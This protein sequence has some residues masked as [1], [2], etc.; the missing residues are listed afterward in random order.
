[1]SQISH[2]LVLRLTDY[3]TQ[4]LITSNTD[5]TVRASTVQAYRFQDSPLKYPIALAVSSGNPD[6]PK[7]LDGRL[8][9]KDANDL[10]LNI[11]SGEIG[12]GHLWWRRGQVKVG[13][14][15]L[16]GKTS[17]EEAGD[18]AH[19]VLGTAMSCIDTC[20]VSDLI[21]EFGERAHWMAV[22][23]DSFFEGG[24]PENQYLWRGTILWQVLTERPF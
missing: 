21:D 22:T 4:E 17:Q 18:R 6:D 3:L 13:C 14:Y 7:Y 10:G 15:Y 23:S 12:G 24:G 16:Q 20:P 8:G 19:R 11:P 2:L 1:M 9:T 5:I